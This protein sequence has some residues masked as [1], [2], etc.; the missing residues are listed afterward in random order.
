MTTFPSHQSSFECI[1]PCKE[2]L[3]FPAAAIT[4]ECA[5]ILS[6]RSFAVGLVRSYHLN[7]LSFERFI[8]RIAVIGTIPDNSSGSSQRESFIEGSLDKGDFMWASRSRVHGDRNTR[9]VCNNH[10]LRTLA[11]LGLSHFEPPFFATTKVPSI[12]HSL[13]SMPPRSSRSRANDSNMLRITPCLTQRLN[14]R[15]QV[16]DEG[17]LSGK[18][19]QQ[20][21]VRNTH[22][23]PSITA[24]S[25]CNTGRP[26]P[27]DLTSAGGIKGAIK[28]HCISVKRWYL[29][30]PNYLT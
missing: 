13:R 26:L 5:S 30:I 28:F 21:P 6:S 1:E 25:S 22:N 11:P 4:P 16:D 27:S 10:E 19:I 2:S 9:S 20:A 29:L 8:K 15:K 12:K 17:N 24:R 23:T 18:S 14:R 7:T 3:H